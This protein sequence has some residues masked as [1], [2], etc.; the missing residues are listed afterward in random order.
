[1][2]VNNNTCSLYLYSEHLQTATVRCTHNASA[3]KTEWNTATV[4]WFVLPFLWARLQCDERSRFLDN[5]IATVLLFVYFVQ[6]A[7]CAYANVYPL[8]SCWCCCCWF[9]YNKFDVCISVTFGLLF[10]CETILCRFQLR[11]NINNYGPCK[12]TRMKSMP[13]FLFQ[14][15]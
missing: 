14:I 6:V 1:M 3:H 2:Y 15:V 4:V 5:S 9:T 12:V 13:M 7:C 10:S 8:F 11:N